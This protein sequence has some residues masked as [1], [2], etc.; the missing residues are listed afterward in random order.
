MCKK[1]NCPIRKGHIGI[2]MTLPKKINNNIIHEN[3]NVKY[4]NL[5]SMFFVPD[6]PQI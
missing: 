1:Q 4:C 5:K 3:K 6:F 2:P